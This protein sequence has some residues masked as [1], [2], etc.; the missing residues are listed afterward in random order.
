MKDIKSLRMRYSKKFMSFRWD[1]AYGMYWDEAWAELHDY[2][3]ETNT[4]FDIRIYHT[5][6]GSM[7]SYGPLTLR[8]YPEK[9]EAILFERV[10]A[11]ND[12][13]S[14]SKLAFRACMDKARLIAEE[15]RVP[16]VTDPALGWLTQ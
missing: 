13:Y 11:D 14:W 12:R 16:L 6:E 5:P 15:M 7:V 3:E 4:P 2:V 10:Y 9:L 8:V 1:T